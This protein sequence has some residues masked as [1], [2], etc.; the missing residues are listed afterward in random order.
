MYICI[1]AYYIYIDIAYV[2]DLYVQLYYVHMCIGAFLLFNFPIS[3]DRMPFNLVTIM[4]KH[5]WSL[6]MIL[7]IINDHV[8]IKNKQNCITY[9]NFIELDP[10]TM[11]AYCMHFM[12]VFPG[13]HHWTQF[14]F[15]SADT[16]SM[17]FTL[18][19]VFVRSG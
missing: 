7:K 10:F 14:T 17:L 5:E 15:I 19:A 8:F 9:P 1:N 12:C 13:E 18:V 16:I 3:N 6:K 2:C 4:M 11:F